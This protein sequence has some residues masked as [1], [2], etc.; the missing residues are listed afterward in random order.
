MSTAIVCEQLSKRYL[1]GE[2]VDVINSIGELAVRF[3]RHGR[4]PRTAR[5]EVWALRE[6]DLEVAEGEV[7][8]IIGRNG[9]GKSTLLKV[10]SRITTPTTGRARVRG[11]VGALLEVGT[12]FDPELTGRENILING[13][14]L[15]M[16][17]RDIRSRF[18]DI[19]DFSGIEAFIDTPVKRYS[20][21]MYLRLGFAVAAHM[22]PE[23]MV[24]DEVLA[25]GD[26][27]FQRRCLN[28]MSELGR[29]G[30]TILYVSH[31]LGSLAHLAS[32]CVWIDAGTVRMDGEPSDVIATYL[33]DG[34]P[35]A[36][37]LALEQRGPSKLTGISLR[38]AHGQTVGAIHRGD[39]LA[40]AISVENDVRMHRL[41]VA[42]WIIDHLGRRIIDEA[43]LDDPGRAGVLDNPGAHAISLELPPLLAPG[44]YTAGVWIGDDTRTHFD[45][46][47]LRF[48]VV[49]DPSDRPEAVSRTR[50]V[51][52]PL[53][54]RHDD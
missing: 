6:L 41:D 29:G 51:S 8:G 45:G 4:Q 23:V 36:E 15:G 7:V 43:F 34:V 16:S 42:V 25:V 31:D 33:R 22:E 9:A 52:P 20:S 48:D 44:T 11:R 27:E 5:D 1:L 37:R 26:A 40:F 24:V 50:L 49:P 46:E 17:R 14:L 3:L 47:A 53:R 38:D 13:A 18:D 21:G 30:R 2:E 19:V 39:T 12:A 54:W 32:R 28:R 35:S 10:L